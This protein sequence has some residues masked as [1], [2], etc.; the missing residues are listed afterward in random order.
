M[1]NFSEIFKVFHSQSLPIFLINS[2]LPL[3]VRF[4]LPPWCFSFGGDFAWSSSRR[5]FCKY[6][7]TATEYRQLSK[8]S[9]KVEQLA[10]PFCGLGLILR[11]GFTCGIG[12][13]LARLLLA[14]RVFLWVV[15]FPSFHKN[16][17]PYLQ[18]RQG[19]T[20]HE[21]PPLKSN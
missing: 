10:Y 17:H 6:I 18:C 14:L 4:S 11:R 19:K 9:W 1:Q 2:D 5:S 20:V 21:V 8:Y 7:I 13:L 15:R 3:S 16:Q 12:L